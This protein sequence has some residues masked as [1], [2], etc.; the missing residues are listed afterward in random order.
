M[1]KNS[2]PHS[3]K[4]QKMVHDQK[5]S[6]EALVSL[7]ELYLQGD[8]VHDA[9]DFFRKAGHREGMDQLKKAAL[10]Q[11]DSFLFK[12]AVGGVPGEGKKEEWEALGNRAMELGKYSYAVSAF[13]AAENEEARKHAREELE[14]LNSQAEKPEENQEQNQT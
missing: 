13:D 10:E 5:L 12:V 9:A 14:K 7:G 4:R 1:K 2:L 8:R 11:G 6:E 3:F